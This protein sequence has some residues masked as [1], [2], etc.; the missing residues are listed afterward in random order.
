M[1]ASSVTAGAYA[2]VRYSPRFHAAWQ[3]RAQRATRLR[4]ALEKCKHLRANT[5]AKGTA[6][7]ATPFTKCDS[8]EDSLESD[9][10]V[11]LFEA[12]SIYRRSTITLPGQYDTDASHNAY[13]LP[14]TRLGA[15]AIDLQTV[16]G[17]PNRILLL[18]AW[19]I[20]QCHDGSPHKKSHPKVA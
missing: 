12:G 4:L 20:S 3:A 1:L 2:T 9:L 6:G 7:A 8:P 16:D 11:T 10:D 19:G 17:G 5:T 18:R 15:R 13:I 14:G